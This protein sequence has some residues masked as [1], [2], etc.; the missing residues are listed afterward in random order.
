ML[1][2][3]LKSGKNEISFKNQGYNLSAH[4]Y[5]PEGFNAASSYPAIV[6]SPAFNQV[7]EQTGAVYGLRLAAL[8]YITVVLAGNHALKTR[9]KYF[10]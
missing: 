10:D 3:N 9:L 6:F 8:G 5:T 2:L 7:K 4:F 1:D